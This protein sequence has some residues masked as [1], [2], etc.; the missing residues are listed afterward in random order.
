M[1]TPKV[2]FLGT[3]FYATE[4]KAK[5][6][7]IADLVDLESR[8]REEFFQD[9]KGKYSDVVG[10]YRTVSST[11]TIGL[12]DEELANALPDSVKYISH[13][14]AGYDQI[15]VPFF[16]ARGI[17]VSNTPGAVTNATADT[18]FFLILGA[19]RNYAHG[20]YQLKQK[21]WLKDVEIGH[22][23][24]GKI[25]GIVGMGGIGQAL[26]DRAIPFGFKVIYYNRRRLASELEKDS[27]YVDNI[28][29]IFT[30]SD[31]IALNVPLTKDT[32]HLVNKDRLAK[33]KPGVIITNSARGPVIDEE[34]LVEALDSGHVGGVGLDV[35]EHEPE[36]HPRLL[37]NPRTLLL[38]HMGT[39]AIETRKNMENL[40]LQNLESG[41]TTG[42]LL[43]LVPEQKGKF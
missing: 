2:L 15:D 20:A 24:E 13:H 14:G 35:F 36:V 18:H 37:D 38:P 1:S 3:V 39:Y 42:K 40:V 21:Q 41:L 27:E 26:R 22:S 6:A 12:F 16:T 9:L 29:E 33:T 31:V 28:D 4:E 7:E 17:Q 32:Y 10:I 5:L 30:Q 25:L 34:A 23:P 43:T 8:S 19:L 11:K